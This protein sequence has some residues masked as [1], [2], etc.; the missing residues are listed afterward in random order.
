MLLQRFHDFATTYFIADAQ[1]LF[2]KS[3]AAWQDKD[4]YESRRDAL[5]GSILWKTAI[6]IVEQD[7]ATLPAHETLEVVPTPEYLRR[8]MP[9]AG[10]F[11]PSAFD[12][13]RKGIYIVT[14]SLDGPIWNDSNMSVSA[15]FATTSSFLCFAIACRMS[16]WWNP[17]GSFSIGSRSTASKVSG[18]LRVMSFIPSIAAS[19]LVETV[20]SE[21]PA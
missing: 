20:E 13:P 18:R 15:R 3:T 12:L 8:V 11:Q 1:A 6:A 10:Y 14:P 2:K 16:V 4:L 9:F 7:L 19:C 5:M 21:R 17:S